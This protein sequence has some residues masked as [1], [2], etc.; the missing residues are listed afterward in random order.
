MEGGREGG[1][2]IA[3]MTKPNPILSARERRERGRERDRD[4]EGG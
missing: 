3:M 1:K 2:G 4:R